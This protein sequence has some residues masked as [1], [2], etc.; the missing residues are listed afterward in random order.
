MGYSL[1]LFDVYHYD[2]LANQ[3]DGV[4]SIVIERINGKKGNSYEGLYYYW[5]AKV[6]LG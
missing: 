4:N 1:F 2:N 5:A 6:R 3:S